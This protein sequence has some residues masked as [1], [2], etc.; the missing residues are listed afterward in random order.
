MEPLQR[1]QL[2]SRRDTML[3]ALGRAEAFINE[4]VEQRDQAQVRLRLEYLDSM[5]ASLEEIQGQLEDT[6]MTNEG[7]AHN[8]AVRAYFEPRLFRIKGELISRLPPPPSVNAQVPPPSHAAS[9]LSGIRL[10]TI[11]LPEFDGDYEQWLPFHD[12]YVALIHDNPDLPEIQK[13]HYLRAAL[14]GEAAQLVESIAISSANYNLAWE[15]LNGRYANE[16]LLKK[17]HLQA[18]FDIPRVKKET[19]ATLHGLVDEF[20]RHIKILHQLGE[21]TDNWSAILE[22]LLCTRLHDDSLRA[23]EDYA[24]TVEDPNYRCLIQF[25]QRRMR[26]LESI[27]VNHHPTNSSTNPQPQQAKRFNNHQ[28]LSSY[29]STEA[30]SGKCPA[31]GEQHP[32][33]RCQ[34]FHESSVAERVRIVNEKRLCINCLRADHIARDCSSN[35]NC[36]QC[37]RRHH[38]LLHNNHSEE[39]RRFNGGGSS[40]SSTTPVVVQ[41]PTPVPHA[42]SVE[43]TTATTAEIVPS[44]ESSTPVNQQTENVFLMTVIVNLVDAFGQE[45]PARALLDSASQPNLVTERIAQ[46]L[47]VKRNRV[48]VTI[49][50][51]GQM[52][53]P[54]RDSIF[55]Q[56]KSRSNDFCCDVGFLVMDKVTANLPAQDISRMGW[57]IPKGITLADPA[58]NR[59]QPID[60]VLGA[61]HFHAFFPTA[62]RLQI[63]DRLPLLVDSVFGWV[64]A[65]S[66]SCTRTEHVPDADE[67]VQSAVVSMISLEQSI[68]RFWMTESL[69][70]NDTYS[71]EERFCET[72]F[73]STTTRNDEGRYM[74]RL[75][76][77]N[78]FAAMLGDSKP[79]ALHRYQLLER[80]LDRNPELK[81]EYDKFMREYLSLDHMKLVNEDDEQPPVSYYLPHHPV[82]KDTSTTTKVRVVFDGSSKASSGFSLNEALCVGPVVQDDLLT[83]IL[84]FRTFLVA[85]VADIAKMYRQILVHPD[86]TALQR[87]LWRF[88]KQTAVQIYELLTVTYGLAPSSFLATRTLK[89]LAADE[90]S[91]Y[92]LGRQALEKCFYVDDFIGG[93]D[94]VEEAI[95]LRTEL[96]ELLEKGGFELR[97]WTSNRL[98]VLHGLNDDQIGT[99][100]SLQFGPNETVKT[101]GISWEPELDFLRFDSQIE[102]ND[103]PWTKRSIL[104]TISKLFD[105]MGLIA[106]VVVSAKILMQQLW[107]LP[108]GWDDPVPEN[109][110]EKWKNYFQ[111]LPKVSTFR[112][113]RYAFLPRSKVQLHTFSDAS[114]DAYGACVY[115]RCE[116]STGN[117]KVQLLASKSR[118]APLKRLSIARL[119]LCAA[120]LGSHL[121]DHVKQALDLE[122]EASYFWTDSTVTLQ[123]LKSPPNVWKTFVA[124]RVAEVQHYTHGCQWRHVP[125]SDNPADLV[126]RGTTVEGLLNS[127][128]WINGPRWLA[129]PQQEW[130]V[131]ALPGVPEEELEIRQVVATIQAQV[132]INPLFLRYD[133]YTRILHVVGYCLRLIS[134]IRAKILER[135]IPPA[136]LDGPTSMPL[137]V[138]HLRIA[139]ACLTR[140]VQEDAF[141]DE[142]RELEKGKSVSKKS[143]IRL[144]N[145]FL[146]SERVLRVGGRLS[147]SQLPYPTKHPALLPANHPFTRLVAEYYHL[148]LFHGGGRHL[149]ATIREEFWP[150]NGRRLV[151]SIV[152]NCFRC[153]RLN[154]EPVEQQ[155]G[156]LPAQRIVPGRPFEVTGVDYAGPIYL[157]PTHKRAPSLKAY[158]CIFVCFTTK[159]VH[160]ELVSDLSTHGFLKALRRFIA[161]RGTPSHLHSDNGKNFEGAKNE[162]V[163]L[164]RM[165]RNSDERDRIRN[166]CVEEGIQWHLTPPKAPHFGGLWE[167]AVKVCKKHLFRQ[168]G[169]IRLSFE[170]MTTVLTQIESIMNSRPLLPITDDPDDLDVLTPAHFLLGTS[171]TALPDPDVS[172]VPASR[173]THYQQLQMHVQQF[174]VRWRDEYLH[175]LQRDPKHRSR[176]DEITPGRMVIVVDEQQAPL[177]WPLARITAIHPGKDNIVRVVSLR[178]AKGTIRRPVTKICLLPFSDATTDPEGNPAISEQPAE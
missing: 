34:Q 44:V 119:E 118:V 1:A 20:E 154:P 88:S 125:G 103:G 14:K 26:V 86:D 166:A 109:V 156:Q 33:P 16:Y 48:N 115:A 13:F 60:L 51:A 54:V 112:V 93:A 24:S 84:R 148:K 50:G 167:A 6:E 53:K 133:S 36:K 76:R 46:L 91:S 45:H 110:Q 42:E 64:V 30:P 67:D 151:R 143:T 59:S 128:C 161:R 5:W 87:I 63:D 41:P 2:L 61:K 136:P 111:D 165:L 171:A 17:R 96:S 117:V 168:L 127:H 170:D 126:S 70:T 140:L 100:S 121:H 89:Q 75:P 172:N 131:L 141:S 8:A 57:K 114:E 79:S 120:V 94:S 21:P 104:S 92:P 7:R 178:T 38:S 176:N 153:T 19:A 157:K 9:A 81:Q 173:L 69:S 15:T 139:K 90:G 137:T 101:L 3:A 158:I 134:N 97:K 174:W 43:Q 98:E 18:L 132:T 68:E 116:D 135:T 123:W 102:P 27:S 49:M 99:Q 150:L 105:P 32:L 80:R 65:G 175:E 144:L 47:R 177:R 4:Y 77:K 164:Y 113:Q 28:R 129:L 66:A 138:E 85:L 107:V 22:H 83:L 52:S 10:P 55:T 29:A 31:C 147:L 71:V 73:Q 35:F 124:N 72:L 160:I 95:R 106:P 78:D 130:P 108:C 25:L 152:R 149:L 159:S 82:I 11:S 23:W 37:H 56:V 162:L 39:G 74:V 40:S 169:N 142:I 62:A 12:T 155:I 163:E 122:I 146:D 58:F 145:P